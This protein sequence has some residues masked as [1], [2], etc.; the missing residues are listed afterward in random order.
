MTCN[1]KSLSARL[2]ILLGVFLLRMPAYAQGDTAGVS[3][4]HLGELLMQLTIYP[5]IGVALSFL[6]FK[7]TGKAW[8]F[9]FAP[10]FYFSLSTIA[11][12]DPTFTPANSPNLFSLAGAW[13]YLTHVVG[14][15]IVYPIYSETKN[16]RYFFFAPIVGWII[17]GGCLAIYL[18]Q[19]GS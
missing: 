1:R 19:I 10:L 3:F 5:F 18:S 13:F 7:A 2:V 4:P 14:I 12:I 16:T 6:I 8:V 17:Q 11:P 9:F 15:A